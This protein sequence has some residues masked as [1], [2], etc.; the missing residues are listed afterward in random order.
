MMHQTKHRP[1]TVGAAACLLFVLQ[2]AIAPTALAQSVEVLTANYIRAAKLGKASF[3]MQVMDLETGEVLVEHNAAEPLIPA[4]NM[5]LVTTASALGIL[6]ADFHFSTRLRLVDKTLIIRGDGDP[7]F[8]D[9]KLL[10][11]MG[12]NMEQLLDRWVDAVKRTNQTAFD[13]LLI[14]DR[15]FDQEFVHP[16]WP[17][18]QLH[19]W[20]CAQVA[21]INFND[22]CLDL[23][24]RPTSN[25]HRPVITIEP[26]DP[27]I[28]LDNDAIS[29]PRN[30]F[31][32]SRKL[33]GNQVVLRGQVRHALTQPANVT[34]HDPPMFFGQLMQR[35]LKA[36]GIEVGEV[37]RVQPQQVLAEGR[38][39]A[40]VQTTLPT[41]V[42]R[43]NHDSQNLFAE[44]LIKRM[45]HQI[46]GQPGGW[47]N[48]AAAIRGFLTRALGSDAASVIIA[49]GSGMSRANRISARDMVG[50]LAYMHNDSGV[51][52]VFAASL[53]AP[54]EPGT[55]EDRFDE[56]NLAGRV[57]AKT[58]YIKGVV[59][60]SGYLTVGDHAVAFGMLLNDYYGS[61]A[62]VKAMM[63]KI[64]AAVDARLAAQN[65]IKLGG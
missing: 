20:Y 21:A 15:A 32:A 38:L 51:G 65:P 49:D 14:D 43:C 12:M 48:G 55:L 57:R 17:L 63:E 9:P 18:N 28:L 27:P 53:A 24:A 8:G 25:G 11:A 26:R 5:K 4:S 7:G 16:D 41:I 40:E 42:T 22:N 19:K 13:A 58:G 45:G 2:L 23:Y 10:E 60:L 33:G 47:S 1:I 30:A 35:R 6:G 62:P 29:G 50:L 56:V 54:G 31:W 52:D 59:T 3:G 64:V 61:T 37:Q 36:A 44:A 46:T 34:F 39:L